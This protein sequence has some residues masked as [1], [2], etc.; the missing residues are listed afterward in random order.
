MIC[1]L[2]RAVAALPSGL[3]LA[4]VLGVFSLQAQTACAPTPAFTPC[5]IV[6]ELSAA[7][8][9][10]H[11]NPYKTVEL[12]AEFRSPR[13]RTFLMPAYWDGG[14]RMVIRFTPAEAG[15]LGFS[16]HQQ[17]CSLRGQDRPVHRHRIGIAW[18]RA[19]RQRAPF[20]I[21]LRAWATRP[22]C[23]WAIPCCASQLVDDAAFRKFVDARAAQK[24]TH[25]RGN[26]LGAPDD[27]AKAFPTPD[28]PDPGYFRQ[29]DERI[30]YINQ[31]GDDRRSAA[32]RR[33]QP[34]ARSC[35]PI[36]SSARATCAT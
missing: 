25:I 30:R 13:H 4:A 35:F 15:E 22:T 29:L 31:K 18:L 26:A 14:Q 21:P 1:G 33:R 2:V 6:F 34:V 7:D 32:G 3:F 5:E 27:T 11:P 8:F 23:G 12:R 36:G 20:R 19:R 28:E 10:S 16:R 24:F 9:A 17:H